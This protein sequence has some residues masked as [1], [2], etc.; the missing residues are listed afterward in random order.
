M[1]TIQPDWF[2]VFM[3]VPIQRKFVPYGEALET[4]ADLRARNIRVISLEF[5]QGGYEI[6]TKEDSNDNKG[7]QS[8]SGDSGGL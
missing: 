1:K 6:V 3:R 8:I 7:K 2:D 5:K 4:L